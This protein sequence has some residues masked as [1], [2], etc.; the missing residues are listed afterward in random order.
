MEQSNS[1]IFYDTAFFCKFY[2]RVE[3]DINPEAEIGRFLT[4]RIRFSNAPPFVGTIEYRRP[5]SK[6]ITLGIFQGYVANQSDAWTFTLNEITHFIDRLLAHRSELT[7]L[8]QLPPSPLE[9][10]EI[11]VPP[12]LERTDG[13]DFT[14]KWPPFSGNAPGEL[15]LAL[16]S[17]TT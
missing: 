1:A 11:P 3:E 2:R 6:A 10:T 12:V 5:H 15:H 13:E 4:E 17:R 14:R 8:P 16:A 9:V 7:E